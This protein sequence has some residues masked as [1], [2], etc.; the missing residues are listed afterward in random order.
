[1]GQRVLVIGAGRSGLAS[2]E[3]LAK[4]D[5]AVILTDMKRPESFLEERL[6]GVSFVW[7]EQP[8]L[9]VLAPD[10]LVMSPGVPLTIPPVVSAREKGIPVIGELELAYRNCQ[11]PFIA[12]TGTNGKTTT[13]TLTGELLKAS[14]KNAVVGGNIGVPLVNIVDT[15]TADH[16]VVAEVSSFQ[17][18]SIDTFAPHIALMLNLTP[19]HLDRHGTMEEYLA[20]KANIFVNQT[21]ND[22]LILNYD[23][24]ALRSLAGTGKGKV[25]FFSQ[26]HILQEGVYLEGDDVVLRYNGQ[27]VSVCRAD[28][29]AIKGKHNLENAM[30]AILLAFFS[31]VPVA[32][33]RTILKTFA[34]VAHRMEP[35]RNWGGVAYINDSKGTNPDATIKAIEAFSQPIILILGGKNKGSDFEHL[36]QLVKQ[37]VKQVVVLGEA[38]HAIVE[39]LEHAGYDAYAKADTFDAAVKMASQLADAG[40][41]VLLSPACASWDMFQ[42]YEERGDAFKKIVQS[43]Q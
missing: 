35:V 23:D 28:E 12:I 22:Y 19:D 16:V 2:A 6:P 27:S 7:G 25:F 43:F 5:N 14:G 17:L 13:T 29:I 41:V 32:T 8:N 21:E 3:F 38:K 31:G 26:K 30:G 36:A 24:E 40:D 33:I 15:L 39:A 18:E 34:G 9:S 1:M 10:L 20:C 4:Q 42:N 11:A 37:R